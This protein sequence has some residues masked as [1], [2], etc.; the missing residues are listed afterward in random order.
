MRAA[1]PPLPQ[2]AF[3][4]W[5]SFEKALAYFLMDRGKIIN[6]IE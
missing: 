6:S 3:K 4:A 2:Y 5:C 1:I